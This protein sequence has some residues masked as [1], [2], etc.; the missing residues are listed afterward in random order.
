MKTKLTR[1]TTLFAALPIL[2]TGCGEMKMKVWPFGGDDNQI[3]SRAPANATEYQCEGN[4]GFFVRTLEGGAAVWL[5]LREREVRLDRVGASSTRYSNSISVLE[6]NGNEATLTDGA[7][8]TYSGCK[9][10]DSKTAN[11]K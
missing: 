6:L 11:S 1:T 8:D 9:T 2:I 10:I 5:I 4:K 3:H 7:T